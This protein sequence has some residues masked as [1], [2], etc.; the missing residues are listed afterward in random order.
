[1]WRVQLELQAQVI[2][3]VRWTL[4]GNAA[5][6]AGPLLAVASAPA[7]GL[8]AIPSGVAAGHALSIAVYLYGMRHAGAQR[9]LDRRLVLFICAVLLSG[10]AMRRFLPFEGWLLSAAV[11]LLVF[12]ALFGIFRPFH[13]IELALAR[14]AG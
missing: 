12:V 4:I 3:Q 2:E 14:R 13:L 5:L 1:M 7:L 11:A 6:V 10:V 8:W 9:I